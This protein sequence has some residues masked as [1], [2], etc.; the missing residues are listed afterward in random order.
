MHPSFSQLCMD[1]YRMIRLLHVLEA[2]IDCYEADEKGQGRLSV[3]LDILDY[4]GA[5]QERCH[6]PLEDLLYEILLVKQPEN[7][8]LIWATRA[9]HKTL[10]KLSAPTVELFFS[11]AN[12]DVVPV[13]SLVR[14]TRNYVARQ[15]EHI[16][17]ENRSVYPLFENNISD[18]EWDQATEK[19]Y[20]KKGFNSNSE[21]RREYEEL[22]RCI[23]R[24]QRLDS[25]DRY[26]QNSLNRN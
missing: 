12:N 10:E 6:R 1:H 20:I 4:I 15:M 26:M 17:Q 14:S 24:N 9:E 22:Y 2:E 21:I 5:Y 11:V 13:Q 7:S 3:I 18:S 8:A 19:A 23:L 25:S 16:S